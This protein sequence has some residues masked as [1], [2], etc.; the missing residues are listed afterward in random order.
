MKRIRLLPV[1]TSVFTYRGETLELPK[2]NTR[3]LHDKYEYI[4]ARQVMQKN[5]TVDE[6]KKVILKHFPS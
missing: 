4:A 2:F 5:M 3:P 1:E 6:Y